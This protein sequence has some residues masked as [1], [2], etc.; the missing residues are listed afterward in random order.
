[1]TRHEP[2][3]PRAPGRREFLTLGVGVFVAASLPLAARRR[4]QLVRR[5]LPVMGT[6]GE[7]VVVHRDPRFAERALDA[8][9]AELARIEGLMTRFAVT[10]DVGR[11]NARAA[12]D[13]V[14]I[15]AE[16]ARVIAHALTWAHAS[17]GAFD[18]ALGVVSELWDVS[19]RT[20]PP[21]ADAVRRLAGRQLYR[22]VDVSLTA[23]AVRLASDVHL[24]LGGIAKGYGIDRA[25]QVL[26]EWGITAAL[27]NVGGDLY[28][29]GA[30]LDGEPWRVGI[31]SPSDPGRLAGQLDVNDEAVAT[32]GDYERFFRHRGVR[33]HHLM[34]PMTAAP[35]QTIEH[36]VTV[37]SPLCIDAD[38]A[39]TAVFGAEPGA[40][41]RLLDARRCGAS[42]VRI[43]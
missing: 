29:L 33:Y 27:V 18:P 39:A 26:R 37:R 13:G 15:S 7:I 3:P 24:D 20:A 22:G 23:P 11:A 40:A 8:A 6:L 4:A 42:L 19:H 43:A 31:Q 2:G 41:R 35:R 5:T 38:A 17:G 28:A 16:T 10:S 34:D 12:H 9:F 36:S 1:M 25:V 30:R 14:A 21:P 32:S